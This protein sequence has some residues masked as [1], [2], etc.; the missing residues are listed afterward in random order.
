MRLIF[1]G[2]NGWYDTSTG[3]T[4]CILVETKSSYII[5]DAGN[6]LYKLDKYI[7]ES[8]EK[9]I[10]LFLSHFH[11]DHIEGLHILNKF[12]FKHGINIY[13][14]SGTK[15]IL[16]TIINKPYTV[17]FDELP[18]NVEINELD[19]GKIYDPFTVHCRFLNH[20]SRCLGY[21]F[22][23][24][25]KVLAYCTDTGVHENIVK[26]GKGADILITEC[27]FKSRQFNRKWPHLNP[28][29]ALHMARKSGAKRLA[30]THFDASIYKSI[31][32][33]DEITS[34]INVESPEIIVAHDNM[35]ITI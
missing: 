16:N 25:N 4:P 32:E 7:D 23:V 28:E 35:E 5:L 29:E 13:G 14:Q 21:R 9:P 6:G 31:E 24:D 34:Q 12:N 15:N 27:S 11:L 2:T 30:L 19:E 22:E 3:N 8:D 10:Y 1:L 18:F 33:R 17:P 20:S 26:L